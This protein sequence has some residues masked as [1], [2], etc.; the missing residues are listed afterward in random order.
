MHLEW[1]TKTL[2]TYYLPASNVIF[3]ALIFGEE[4]EPSTLYFIIPLI[5][6]Q[7]TKVMTVAFYDAR[8]CLFFEKW[9]ILQYPLKLF[10]ILMN[11]RRE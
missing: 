8:R 7:L 4:L 10:L 9:K 3:Q 6:A 11:N 5:N 2:Y 1:V